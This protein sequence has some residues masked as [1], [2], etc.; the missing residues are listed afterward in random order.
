MEKFIELKEQFEEERKMYM[1][2]L[3]TSKQERKALVKYL[4][5]KEQDIAEVDE[6]KEI[7]N[8]EKAKQAAYAETVEKIMASIS[9]DLVAALN[10]QANASML[11]DVT[12]AVAPYA[13][14]KDE[15]ISDF[16]NKML[17]GTSIEGI[18]DNFS[19]KNEE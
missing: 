7:A 18:I 6:V 12:G 11:E 13:I 4:E 16:T 10:A 9:P 3:K 15:S 1:F 8:I 17:R 5:V 14:A 2:A 19:K